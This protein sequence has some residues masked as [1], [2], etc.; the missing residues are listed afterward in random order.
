MLGSTTYDLVKGLRFDDCE[1]ARRV[2]KVKHHEELMEAWELMPFASRAQELKIAE[3]AY[4]RTTRAHRISERLHVREQDR[5]KVMSPHG[6]GSLLNFS[7]SGVSVAFNEALG[8]GAEVTLWFESREPGLAKRLLEGGVDRIQGEVR[9]SYLSAQGMVHGIMFKDLTP[10]QS[11]YFAKTMSEFAFMPAD[12]NLR[13]QGVVHG[14]K[15][16]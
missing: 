8:R 13:L 2:I 4:S 10:D 6:D 3:D 1:F 7:G 12:T 16:V 14:D 9:W 15:A 11:E 5:V